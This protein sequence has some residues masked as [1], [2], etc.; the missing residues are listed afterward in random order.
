MAILGSPRNGAIL[1][2]EFNPH[3]LELASDG[4]MVK[5]RAVIV[6]S[7]QH[8]RRG[9]L[10][11]VVPIS[12]TPPKVLEPWHVEIPLDCIPAPARSKQG[13]RWAKCDMVVTVGWSRLNRYEGPRRGGRVTYY[14]SYVDQETVVR[15]KKAVAS[16]FGIRKSLWE[17]G[18]AA[19]AAEDQLHT[20]MAKIDGG[21][22]MAA[23]AAPEA[24]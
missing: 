8:Q 7:P 21:T 20:A 15:L 14:D 22:P 1:M 17:Y 2:C 6:L 13:T 9:K 12:M 4:N 10:L 3:E 18:Q 23:E 16:V 24:E 19:S 11:H 5:T